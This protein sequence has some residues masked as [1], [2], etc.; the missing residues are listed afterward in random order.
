MPGLRRSTGA[1]FLPVA[2]GNQ[3][4]QELLEGAVCFRGPLMVATDRDLAA[5]LDDGFCRSRVEPQKL[6]PGLVLG[7]RL[8]LDSVGG[9]V[10]APAAG[11]A[12]APHFQK[13][14]LFHDQRSSAADA[15]AAIASNPRQASERIMWCM[16]LCCVLDAGNDGGLKAEL[17][18]VALRAW[19]R[20]RWA[21][22]GYVAPGLAA[23]G[24]WQKR[25]HESRAIL[26]RFFWR[27]G[28]LTAQKQ[29]R[30]L[31]I[32]GRRQVPT[33]STLRIDKPWKSLYRPVNRSKPSP[34]SMVAPRENRA[35][36]NSM[37]SLPVRESTVIWSTRQ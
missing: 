37:R 28:G 9:G 3:L 11:E 1:G 31:K 17:T 22:G 4:N 27:F 35:P 33:A 25:G 18:A 8:T 16:T 12:A 6:A 23:A 5:P 7:L 29:R 2:A 14:R 32:G 34:P 13:A 30:C 10:L 19:R 24:V 21:P 20:F 26:R 15:Q 36:T